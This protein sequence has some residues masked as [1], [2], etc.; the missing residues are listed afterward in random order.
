MKP[1]FVTGCDVVDIHRVAA[2]IRRR[3]GVI[4][5]LF[6]KTE[7]RD[8]LRDGVSIFSDVAAARFAARFAA[9]EATRKALRSRG[10]SWQSIEV[11]TASDGAPNLHV[12][13]SPSALALS[14]SHDGG[15]A[16]AVVVGLVDDTQ[17]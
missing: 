1:S 3:P 6:T 14:L 8:V 15:V 17:A 9:K 7:Q 11:C 10:L 5:R 12:N 4:N 16:F 13:G 2:V